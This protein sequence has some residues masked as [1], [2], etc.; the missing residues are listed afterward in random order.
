MRA[1]QGETTFDRASIYA[2][3]IVDSKQYENARARTLIAD[4][5]NR[6]Q[7]VKAMAAFGGE[8]EPRNPR[9]GLRD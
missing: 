3:D 6:E 4:Q 5:S 7:L 8:L 9:Q 2:I 1:R